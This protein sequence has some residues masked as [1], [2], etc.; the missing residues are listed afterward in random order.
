[1]IYITIVNVPFWI[2]EVRPVGDADGR[3]E[4][5]ADGADGT[6]AEAGHAVDFRGDVARKVIVD[7]VAEPVDGVGMHQ[8]VGGH[9]ILLDVLEVHVVV[10]GGG[11]GPGEVLEQLDGQVDGDGVLDTALGEFLEVVEPAG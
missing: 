7:Q 9:P 8:A 1:M 11:V 3:G 5:V 10:E 6:F 2:A 4:H